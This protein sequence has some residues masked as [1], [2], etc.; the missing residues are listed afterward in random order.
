MQSLI[1]NL[2]MLLAQTPQEKKLTLLYVGLFAFGLVLLL[3]DSR[4][5]KKWVGGNK[6]LGRIIVVVLFLVI[7]TFVVLYFVL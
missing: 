6:I 4:E 1:M 2:N 3:I 7:I 5:A